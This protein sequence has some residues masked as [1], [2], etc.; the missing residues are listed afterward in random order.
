MSKFIIDGAHKLSGRIDV[1]GSKN[2]AL[3]IIFSTVATRGVSTLY[4]VPDITDVRVALALIKNMGAR[5][6]RSGDALYIDT[7][8]LVYSLPDTNLVSS[9]RASSYLLGATLA[10]FGRA[11]IQRFGGCNFDNRPIDMHLFAMHKFGAVQDGELLFV[12]KLSGADIVFAKQSVGATV[13]A[14]ILAA[15]AE[16]VSKI[17]GYAKEPHVIALADFLISCGAKITFLEDH[18]EITGTE[19]HGGRSHII[20]DMIEAGTYMIM[21]L[22]TGSSIEIC[23]AEG[24]HIA[25][26]TRML[27]AA[28][29]QFLFREGSITVGGSLDGYIEAVT[30]PYPGFPTDLQPQ[31]AAL[32][33]IAKGG[34][35]TEGVWHSRFGYLSEMTKFGVEYSRLG[36]TATVFPSKLRAASAEATDLRGGAALVI[37]ALSAKGKSVISS[38]QIVNRGYENIVNKL[39]GV[40]AEIIEI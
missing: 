8:H 16:G 38:S 40:G 36:D 9:I 19:L 1:S 26:L 12:K 32:M 20:P 28:G 2:A 27:S 30:A 22:A 35:I 37:A 4:G 31:L 25:S 11:H 24:A 39:R 29:A 33:A 6:V 7:C 15:S 34:K 23:G 21:A 13:N 3:P 17:Y 14:L 5:V 18:I 10:R